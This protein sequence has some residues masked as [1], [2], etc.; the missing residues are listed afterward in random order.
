[1]QMG[2]AAKARSQIAVQLDDGQPPQAL[3]Q[4]LGER[5]QAGA[6]FHHGLPRAGGNGADDGVNH[7]FVAQKMLA[8][9]FAG[10]VFHGVAPLPQGALKKAGHHRCHENRRFLPC[11]FFVAACRGMGA[12]RS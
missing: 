6:D 9:A 4:R 2:L 11:F 8:E 5:G 1:M 3:K 10:N 7:G 12:W